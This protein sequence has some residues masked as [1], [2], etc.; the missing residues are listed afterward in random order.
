MSVRAVTE[1]VLPNAPV[2]YGHP[3]PED[4]GCAL[5]LP[6]ISGP[7]LAAVKTACLDMCVLEYTVCGLCSPYIN[8]PA[9]R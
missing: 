9:G 8:S 7:T 6:C 3:Y 1:P 5:R 4:A 2:V